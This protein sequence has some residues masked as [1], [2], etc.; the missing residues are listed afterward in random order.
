MPSSAWGPQQNPLLLAV[1]GMVSERAKAAALPTEGADADYDDGDS[2]NGN[3][4]DD[5]HDDNDDDDDG[6]DGQQ[7]T[8]LFST[9]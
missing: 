9:L 5:D 3:D 4:N 2:D 1:A 6:D 7:L 8:L